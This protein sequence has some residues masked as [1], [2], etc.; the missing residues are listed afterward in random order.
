MSLKDPEILPR[1]D[2]S[3]A[4][5]SLE[6]VLKTVILPMRLADPSQPQRVQ[7][8]SDARHQVMDAHWTLIK[9][10]LRG[11]ISPFFFFLWSHLWHMKVPGLGVE[12][13]LQL[14]AYSTATTTPAL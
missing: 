8:Q 10:M 7:L 13:E 5:S 6:K 12:L 9:M 1:N 3:R 4:Q 14:L 11:N 2:S